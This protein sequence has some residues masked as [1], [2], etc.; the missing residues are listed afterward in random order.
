ML[1]KAS[2]VGILLALFLRIFGVGALL[3]YHCQNLVEH[4]YRV[5]I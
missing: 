3:T 4:I 2:F 1:L 5:E